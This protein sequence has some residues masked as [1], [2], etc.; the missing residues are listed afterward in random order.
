MQIATANT[1]MAD[2]IQ[3]SAIPKPAPAAAIGQPTGQRSR[4]EV[5]IAA[6]DSEAA[7][8]SLHANARSNIA[9]VMPESLPTPKRCKAARQRSTAPA[10]PVSKTSLRRSPPARN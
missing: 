8:R 1:Q 10:S 7:A 4:W 2:M 5:Q 9:E 3:V 6:T